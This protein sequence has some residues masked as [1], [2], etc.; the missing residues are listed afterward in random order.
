MADT[1]ALGIIADDVLSPAI[2][3]HALD[4]LMAKFDARKDSGSRR[5]SID[6]A[7]K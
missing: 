5:V 2:L 7:V 6:S 4:K 1:A 3:S